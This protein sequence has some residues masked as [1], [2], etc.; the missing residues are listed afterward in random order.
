MSRHTSDDDT[1]DSNDEISEI[2]NAMRICRTRQKAFHD[3]LG[4]ENK[5]VI[6]TKENEV[7]NSQIYRSL[8]KQHCEAIV[9]LEKKCM[10]LEDELNYTKK[11]LKTKRKK[12][13]GR[14]S[15]G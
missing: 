8:K 10:A 13:A 1:E 2:K 6:D 5:H 12:F 9:K 14:N 7:E 3:A 11:I 4:E 15:T